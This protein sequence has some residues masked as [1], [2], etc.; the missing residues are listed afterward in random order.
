MVKAKITPPRN[1]IERNLALTGSLIHY[2]LEQPNLLASLPENFELVVL[3]DD[4]PEIRLYNLELLDNYGSQGRPI[5]FA[6][7]KSSRDSMKKP[8]IA[9][10][11]VPAVTT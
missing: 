1:V 4:D 10:L 7:V 3:P 9:D 2:L 11:Y 8:E 6:R 5:V